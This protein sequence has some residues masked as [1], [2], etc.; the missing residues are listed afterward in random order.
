MNEPKPKPY[1]RVRAA[2]EMTGYNTYERMAQAV[3]M[4]LSAF[5]QKINGN[6]EF[7]LTECNM[8]ATKLGTTLDKIFFAPIVPE[9]DKKQ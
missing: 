6:R 7:T 4:S 3:G 5:S 1:E 8:I 2:M 9:W